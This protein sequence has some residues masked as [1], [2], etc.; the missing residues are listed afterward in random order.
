MA[1]ERSGNPSGDD[2]GDLRDLFPGSE[3]SG[4]TP[5][6]PAGKKK[7]PPAPRSATPADP[8]GVAADGW[9][10]WMGEADPSLAPTQA[11]ARPPASR[12]PMPAAPGPKPPAGKAA[13]GARTPPAAAERTAAPAKPAPADQAP[14]AKAV[15]LPAAPAS[16]P[17]APRRWLRSLIVAFGVFL[18]LIAGEM[19]ARSR[20]D[21]AL[22]FQ[23]V[24]QDAR[25]RLPASIPTSM[26]PSIAV[27]LATVLGGVV[28]WQAGKPRRPV[29]LPVAL[30]LCL[31]SAAFGLFRG[32]REFDVE[33]SASLFRGRVVSLESDLRKMRKDLGE[34]QKVAAKQLS[35]K[36]QAMAKAL[37]GFEL[38]L[39]EQTV[40]LQEAQAER[41]KM[42]GSLQQSSI[43]HQAS[44]KEKDELLSALR[45]E[46]EELR[47]K[48]AE[49]N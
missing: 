35:D 43:A 24:V 22:K 12:R 47:R 27:G 26:L 20:P 31:A 13:A 15:P 21:S 11:P 18:A 33:R 2:S 29:F 8:S 39:R 10:S 32:G 6:P 3:S 9:P 14:V 25:E 23:E 38:K 16:E 42:A 40:R 49:K 7:A 41:D 34:W 5:K 44:L 37:E 17:K 36:D 1:N 45:R 28:V 46:I 19:T 30:L 4:G 48:L